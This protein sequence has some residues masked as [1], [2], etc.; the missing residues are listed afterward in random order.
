MAGTS[1]SI[2][3]ASQAF[4]WHVIEVDGH[5]VGAIDAAYAEAISHDRPP[6][7][8]RRPDRQGQRRERASPIG[9]ACTGSRSTTT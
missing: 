7:S 2:R 8:D 9:T 3:G 1:A 4:G 5:D 6:D